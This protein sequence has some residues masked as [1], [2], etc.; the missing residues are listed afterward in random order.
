MMLRNVKHNLV[1][2]FFLNRLQLKG[3]DRSIQINEVE[4]SL[5]DALYA[6]I[7]ELDY[8]GREMNKSS[9]HGSDK[10]ENTKTKLF[11][12]GKELLKLNLDN[13]I[14]NKISIKSNHLFAIYDSIEEDPEFHLFGK[15]INIEKKVKQT[16][17][18]KKKI[19]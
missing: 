5:L 15:K 14:K 17:E 19:Y 2:L 7:Y 16:T 18:V 13:E 1:D 11:I 10:I 9:Q 4:D 8:P 12:S 3:K 6:T